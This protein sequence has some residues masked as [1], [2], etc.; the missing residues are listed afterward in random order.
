MKYFS[1]EVNENRHLKDMAKNS[2]N[3]SVAVA[4]GTICT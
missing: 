1:I 2:P 3:N 4:T